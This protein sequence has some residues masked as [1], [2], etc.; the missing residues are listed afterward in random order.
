VIRNFTA[1]DV[2]LL[3][4]KFREALKEGDQS[5]VVALGLTSQAI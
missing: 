5:G 3:V 4:F 1:R 2:K